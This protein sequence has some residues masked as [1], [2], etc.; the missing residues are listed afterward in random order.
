[1]SKKNH[2]IKKLFK[3]RASLKTD[4]FIKYIVSRPICRAAIISGDF[5]LNDIE[6]FKYHAELK[7]YNEL[8][9]SI[10]NDELDIQD[11][12]EFD[13]SNSF[14]EIDDFT[15]D[16]ISNNNED[17]NLSSFLYDE[18]YFSFNDDFI[19]ETI[20]FNNKEIFSTPEK[21]DLKEI[22]S[23][24]S[25]DFKE[26]IKTDKTEFF[27]RT[28]LFY[29]DH[30]VFLY[31]FEKT[32]ELLEKAL[33]FSNSMHNIDLYETIGDF[34]EEKN[35]TNY[36]YKDVTNEEILFFYTLTFLQK[37]NKKLK[38]FK[39][40]N[41]HIE[42]YFSAIAYLIV[43]QIKQIPFK[44][45]LKNF[46]YYVDDDVKAERFF[47]QIFN[48]NINNIIN[49]D[50]VYNSLK[51]YQKEYH[52]THTLSITNG[53]FGEKPEIEKNPDDLM[54]SIHNHV[55][56]GGALVFYDESEMKIH[57]FQFD[58]EENTYKM[59][60]KEKTPAAYQVLKD[61]FTSVFKLKVI[62]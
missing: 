58:A 2:I 48:E 15:F 23:Q 11:L 10:N 3:K 24:L 16:D 45:M 61:I 42:K 59:V 14:D 60:L 25:I 40:T 33:L 19:K 38:I 35:W 56:F 31:F 12:F 6:K 29:L 36:T 7:K 21:N 46:D 34:L 30:F 13:E 9:D 54:L 8:L 39:K 53:Y 49:T 26:N 44:D 18:K 55:Y 37:M 27:N 62:D 5:K 17:E 4:E 32:Y 43:D 51:K 20:I 1:M 50:V 47:R 28:C 57:C 22:F 52:I 41:K